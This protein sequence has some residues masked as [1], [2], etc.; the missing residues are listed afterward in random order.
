MKDRSIR[1]VMPEAVSKVLWGDRKKWGLYPDTQ[2]NDWL[3]WQKQY[4]HFYESNQ[5]KG[6][7]TIVNDAG[8]SILQQVDMANKNVLEVGP[9][10]IRHGQ[11]WNSKPKKYYLA[12]IHNDMLVKA[13]KYLEKNDVEFEDILVKRGQNIPL[14]DSSVDLIISFYSLEHIYP[15]V[16]YLEET[17]RLLKSGGCLIGAIPTEG[18]FAWGL[19]RFLTSRKWFKRNTSID[20]DKIICWEHPNFCS[21]IINDLEQ[22]FKIKQLDYYPFSM[23]PHH[24]VNLVLKFVCEKEPS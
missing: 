12:D 16:P 19:G 22:V 23:V 3:E 20:P 9:G 1:N 24:D 5:R 2:D 15:L 17:K 4:S 14:P 7:G 13:K 6:V 11:Y 21:Q 18:G 8:Y 10:D